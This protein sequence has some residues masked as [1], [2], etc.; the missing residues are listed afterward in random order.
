MVII[1][2]K[3]CVICVERGDIPALVV[4]AICP[5]YAPG[6][7]IVVS[8]SAT[9]AAQDNVCLPRCVPILSLWLRIRLQGSFHKAILALLSS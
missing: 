4:G 8:T 1:M 9:A 2:Y 5:R 3:G 6:Q 7:S